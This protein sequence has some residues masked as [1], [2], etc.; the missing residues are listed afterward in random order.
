MGGFVEQ[1]KIMS[2]THS[3]LMDAFKENVGDND[4]FNDILN[5]FKLYNDNCQITRFPDKNLKEILIKFKKSEIYD[6][7]K[8]MKN[9]YFKIFQ[10]YY[11]AHRSKYGPFYERFKLANDY[12]TLI[13][14]QKDYL[15]YKKY[16]SI[17]DKKFKKKKISN[18]F[19]LVLIAYI[20]LEYESEKYSFIEN[21][22]SDEFSIN[23]SVG[24]GNIDEKVTQYFDL[25]AEKEN[26]GYI[27]S[28]SSKSSKVYYEYEDNDDNQQDYSYHSENN[29]NYSHHNTS[30]SSSGNYG[31]YNSN[32]TSSNYS[33]DHKKESN[34]K[35]KVKVIMCY[36]CKSKNL[37]PL[38]GNKVK[39]RVSLGNLYAH[40]NCYN[41]GKCC[42]CNK[43]GPGNHV[44]SICSDC[45]KS[46]ISKGLTG[47]ARCFV[48]R[49]LM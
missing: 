25:L 42:L 6:I 1:A 12:E 47:S 30:N 38:C 39:S 36:S 20:K 18:Q 46:T 22:L 8:E 19:S 17:Y 29:Y 49:N 13:K 32:N 34:K 45:R 43:K 41:E 48:C 3:E 24:Y 26:N 4:K 27:S 33:N 2:M 35:K 11:K 37:C 40:S 16:K 31:N 5:N 10:N 14:E 9:E 7:I 21:H 28:Q 15:I 44:Q 23:T